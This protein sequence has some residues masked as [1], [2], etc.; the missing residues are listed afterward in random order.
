MV[1]PLK[2]E[3]ARTL[4]LR[5]GLYTRKLICDPALPTDIVEALWDG[6]DDRLISSA[7]PLQVK[8]RCVVVRYDHSQSSFLLK[9]HIWGPMSRSIRM[10]L[11]EP[12]AHRCASLA[13]YLIAQGI[14][15]PQ[16]RSCL[17]HGFGPLSHRSYLLTDFV[18]GSSLF[19]YIRSETPSTET[20]GVLARQV[21]TI[22]D[23]LISLDISHN[24]LKPE[25]FIVDSGLRVWII[26]FE[27]MR[28][29]HDKGQLRRRHL[30][31]VRNFLH[32]RSWRDQPGA[33]EIFRQELLKT[34]LGKWLDRGP[35]DEHRLLSQGYSSNELSGRISVAI[36]AE[37]RALEQQL[38]AKTIDSV[39]DLADEIVLV[40]PSSS[41][42]QF[43]VWETIEPRHSRHSHTLAPIKPG[44]TQSGLKKLQH[45]WV[46]LLHVGEC[47]T[48]DLVRQLPERI[49]DQTECDAVRIPID[50]TMFGNS[51]HRYLLSKCT[52]IRIFHQ[53]RCQFSLQNGALIITADPDKTRSMD[54]RIL[55]HVSPRLDDY[56]TRLNQQTSRAATEMFQQGHR[57][58]LL[59]GIARAT[60][61]FARKYFLEGVFRRGWI[62]LQT[63]LLSALFVWIQEAKLWQLASK[64]Q[65]WRKPIYGADQGPEKSTHHH[66]THDSQSLSEAA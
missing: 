16:P 42:G 36:V 56:V 12:T 3:L 53:D 31:D 7:T 47:A 30:R 34:S 14:P 26:D 13:N 15:T 59:K 19:H 63:A 8:D 18:E 32:V 21:A 1:H 27:K 51:T 25:N 41:N 10:L 23:Q 44:T 22:W 46:L 39:N 24:D 55:H 9:R 62:G 43:D 35:S 61:Q 11:R 33:V 45:P 5:R 57:A 64:N 28:I 52:P 60:Y 37:N 54:A 66:G 4:T 29:H 17:V 40:A 20:V 58:H 49:V 50:E 48:P 65:K 6:P 38:L 2:Q